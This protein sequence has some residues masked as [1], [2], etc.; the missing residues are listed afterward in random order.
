MGLKT[1]RHVS[2]AI[3]IGEDWFL[4][5]VTENPCISTI[6]DPHA[7]RMIDQDFRVWKNRSEVL[8]GTLQDMRINVFETVEDF[9]E[10]T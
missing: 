3:K 10:S 8:D 4:I 6:D 5:D 1:S 7:L 2:N 9:V